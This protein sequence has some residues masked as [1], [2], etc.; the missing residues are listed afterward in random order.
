MLKTLIGVNSFQ[1]SKLRATKRARIDNLNDSK[2]NL[3]IT[4]SQ[5][6]QIVL[7]M[8]ITSS[9]LYQT[10]NM[11][12]KLAHDIDHMEYV[13]YSKLFKVYVMMAYCSEYTVM[14]PYLTEIFQIH[15]DIEQ[16]SL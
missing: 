11:L 16:V 14:F 13:L 8:P 15:S 10:S 2:E 6:Q 5:V 3:C 7:Q 1:V 4:F 12:D 9:S